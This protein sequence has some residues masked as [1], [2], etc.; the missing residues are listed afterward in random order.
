MKVNAIFVETNGPEGRRVALECSVCGIRFFDRMSRG[1]H[2]RVLESGVS[3]FID[4]AE[5]AHQSTGGTIRVPRKAV[6]A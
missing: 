1:E 6:A 3:Q 2:P 5:N 4:H